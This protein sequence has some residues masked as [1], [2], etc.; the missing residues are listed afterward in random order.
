MNENNNE[1]SELQLFISQVSGEIY[2]IEKDEIDNVDEF[3]IPLTKRPDSSCNR[4]YG[5]G[6]SGRRVDSGVLVLCMRCLRKCID[7]DLLKELSKKVK[8]NEKTN[9]LVS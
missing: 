6:Y 5:R 2:S 3:Q 9:K 4:C 1:V 8:E 7:F